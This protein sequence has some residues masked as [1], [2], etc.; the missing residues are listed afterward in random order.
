MLQWRGTGMTGGERLARAVLLFYQG[1]RW[2]EDNQDEWTALTGSTEATTKALGD[3]AREVLGD[4]QAKAAPPPQPHPPS[5]AKRLPQPAPDVDA[6]HTYLRRITKGIRDVGTRVPREG[7]P[8]YGRCF[9][10]IAPRLTKSDQAERQRQMEAALAANGLS[11]RRKD[12]RE[13]E[14]LGLPEGDA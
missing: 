1:A 2:S 11:C 5:S 8:E 3:L 10:F 6:R 7:H 13:F 9:I 4:E 14:I 12:E